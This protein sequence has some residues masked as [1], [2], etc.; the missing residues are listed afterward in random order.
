MK[1]IFST[2]LLG[3]FLTLGMSSCVKKDF[4][5]PPYGGDIDPKLPVNSSIWNLKQLYYN[6]PSKSAVI[7]QDYTI[8]GVVVAN[9]ESGNFYKQIIIQDSS[10]AIAININRS[11][12]YS[13]FP[14]G[15][16]VYIK[17]RGLVLG[18]YNDFIQ[19][20][21][22]F[23][24][25]GSVVE[26]PSTLMNDYV[27]KANYPVAVTPITMSIADLQTVA[28]NEK[29]VGMLIKIDRAQ[30]ISG[31]VGQ[32]FAVSPDISSGTDRTLEDCSHASIVLRTSGYSN[33]RA[34]KLPNNSGAVYCIYSR[35]RNDAQLILRDLNDL[36]FD[37]ERCPFGSATDTLMR[38]GDL[39]NMYQGVPI[40]I[41]NRR[42]RGTVISDLDPNVGDN[43]T[44]RNMVLQDGDRGIVV[45]FSAFGENT[46]ALGD[47][48]EVIISG[49]TLSEFGNL[50]QIGDQVLGANVQK[51]G[52]GN[53]ISRTTTIAD[54]INNFE[55]WE[56]TLVTIPNATLVSGQ[57][58]TYQGIIDLNDNSSQTNFPMFTQSYASFANTTAPIGQTKSITGFLYSISTANRISIRRL[59]DVQ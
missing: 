55:D 52:T 51:L 6:S 49:Q 4:D 47:S 12:L 1:S 37:T 59:T 3:I 54:I 22:G 18:H 43:I 38:I 41:N 11:S 8:S 40:V 2:F 30:F 36:K 57:N 14:L 33:F 56:S 25:D 7:D 50:L 29:M 13:D 35:Y 44:G 45:R 39:R 32:T 28:T 34:E 42:I 27:V 5:S 24:T 46:W 58:T 31:E 48:I 23:D 15:R 16:K 26:I 9:D 20:G 53:V 21:Y 10:A 17:C 19:M